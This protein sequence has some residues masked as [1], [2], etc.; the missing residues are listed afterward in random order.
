VSPIGDGGS[1]P[2]CLW[3]SALRRRG[4][5]PYSFHRVVMPRSF[6]CDSVVVVDWP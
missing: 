4:F 6:H 5:L 2:P 3:P 1:R